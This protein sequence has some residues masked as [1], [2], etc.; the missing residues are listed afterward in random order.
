MGMV[1]RAGAGLLAG[2]V[3]TLTLE[4]ATFADMAA[5][6]RPSSDLPGQAAARLA[7]KLGVDLDDQDDTSQARLEG[8]GSLLGYGTGLVAALAWSIAGLGR[9]AP[10]WKEAAGLGLTAMALA[11]MPMVAQGLT[12]PRQWGWK[13]WLADLAP[14]LAYGV[15]AV[16]VMRYLR[17]RR[18]SRSR[19]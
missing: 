8:L 7:K 6:G 1:G 10:P 15:A 16:G 3:G 9:K 12:D 2:A 17:A 5:R 4:A 13:G 11:D 18:P 19:S 14:H